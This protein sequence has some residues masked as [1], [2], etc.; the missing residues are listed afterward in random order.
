MALMTYL[1]KDRNGTYYFPRVIPPSDR[2]E[3]GDTRPTLSLSI[4]GLGESNE[5]IERP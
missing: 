3:S 2:H 4:N 5:R 1:L